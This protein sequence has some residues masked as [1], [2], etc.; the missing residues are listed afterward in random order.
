MVVVI[1]GSMKC[2]IRLP[3]DTHIKWAGHVIR[4]EEQS[5]TRIVLVAAV[6]GRRQRGRPKLRWEDGVMEDGV[7]ED[8]M[9]GDG[10]MGDG[11]MGD[12]VMGDGVMEDARKLG[13]EKLE[14][15]CK[16]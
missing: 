8:G 2:V 10:V 13:G 11:V 15:W 14:E 3:K 9:M 7:M 12:G 6:E 5:A 1:N 16:E 4:K